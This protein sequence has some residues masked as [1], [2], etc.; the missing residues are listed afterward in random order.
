[1]KEQ[2][3]RARAAFTVYYDFRIPFDYENQSNYDILEK[4]CN[5]EI[6]TK[7]GGTWTDPSF[8]MD[9]RVLEANNITVVGVEWDSD[10]VATGRER[11][12]REWEMTVECEDNKETI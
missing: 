2:I 5:Q 1:M 11:F 9:T 10:P 6:F 3:L 7:I 12:C 4:L 8:G